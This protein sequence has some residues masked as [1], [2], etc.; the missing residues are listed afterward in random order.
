MRT[1]ENV[2]A[3]ALRKL[4]LS[5]RYLFAKS[6]TNGVTRF[7]ALKLSS[8]DDTA[9]FEYRPEGLDE[10]FRTVLVPDVDF[11]DGVTHTLLVSVYG[12]AFFL[13]VDGNLHFQSL[14]V[15]PVEDGPGSLLLGTVSGSSVFFSGETDS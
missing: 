8:E 6:T 12:N 2:R 10:G 7:Y 13:F 14:L 1:S 11:A 4:L 5:C 9:L 3:F 15:G